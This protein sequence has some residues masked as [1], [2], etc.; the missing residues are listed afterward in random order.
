MRPVKKRVFEIS[1]CN[2]LQIYMHGPFSFGAI[3]LQQLSIILPGR[4]ARFELCTSHPVFAKLA[5][6]V[7]ISLLSC[8]SASV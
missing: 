5:H 2:S 6:A 3:F 8:L 4:R 1:K 7:I